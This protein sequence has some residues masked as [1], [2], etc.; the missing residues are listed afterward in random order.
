MCF[1][2]RLSRALVG[3]LLTRIWSD[4]VD[5]IAMC[6]R[7][8]IYRCG[9]VVSGYDDVGPT[10]EENI[11]MDF[12]VDQSDL[13]NQIEDKP[14]YHKTDRRKA[15]EMV[16]S[17]GNGCFLVRPSSKH[18]LTL[19]LW[20]NNR[21]YNIPIRK[22]EDQKISLG[23]R[24]PN[25]KFFETIEDLIMFYHSEELILFSRGEK[26]GKCALRCCPAQVSKVQRHVIIELMPEYIIHI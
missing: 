25:E 20:Y 1:Y 4:L 6:K 2:V 24:K 8:C 13:A 21:A 23:N 16:F 9:M 26:T 7:R 12:D 5:S 3:N 15:Q 22:R 14:W 11:N 17:G 10:N 19:T 18:A